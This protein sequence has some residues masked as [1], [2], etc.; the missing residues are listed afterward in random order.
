[1]KYPDGPGSKG[2]ATSG[3]AAAEMQAD[4]RAVTL[5]NRVTDWYGAGNVGTA[6][7]CAAALGEPVLAVRPRVAELHKRGH[8][9]ATDERRRNVGGRMAAVW[10]RRELPK[11]PP[12]LRQMEMFG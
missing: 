11:P 9:E 7:E 8:I 3:Q 4:G 1:M 6:D 10:R 12:P 2:F 5:R